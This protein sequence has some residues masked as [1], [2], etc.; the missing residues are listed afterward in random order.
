MQPSRLK[1][2]QAQKPGTTFT[3]LYLVF[4]N[5]NNSNNVVKQAKVITLYAG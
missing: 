5:A 4:S 1:A 2:L 3:H